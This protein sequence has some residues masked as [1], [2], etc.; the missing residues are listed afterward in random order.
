MR[1]VGIDPAE[2]AVSKVV[3]IGE[4]LRN[5]DLSLVKI[6]S[7]IEEMWNASVY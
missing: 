1:E 4:S 6:G 3:C 7:D 2:T 5:R